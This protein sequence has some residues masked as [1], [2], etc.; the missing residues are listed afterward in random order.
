MTRHSS[1]K[2]DFL[3]IATIRAW[4]SLEVL[5]MKHVGNRLYVKKREH[6]HAVENWNHLCVHAIDFCLPESS[7]LPLD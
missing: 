2:S 4:R 6:A 5:G 1:P 3:R 7:P